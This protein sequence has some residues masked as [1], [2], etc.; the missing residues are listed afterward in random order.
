MSWSTSFWSFCHKLVLFLLASWIMP[1]HS[2]IKTQDSLLRLQFFTLLCKVLITYSL[3]SRNGEV[4]RARPYHQCVS[5]SIPGLHVIHVCGLSLVLVLY[6]T[7]K[8]FFSLYSCLSLSSKT[9]I[10]KFRFDPGMHMHLWTSSCE[11]LGALWL[12]K[13]HCIML[14]YLLWVPP[15]EARFLTLTTVGGE[16]PSIT[17]VP[18]KRLVVTS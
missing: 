16:G 14:H 2:L 18:Y 5:S 17:L 6:F 3:G 9:N 12:I 8:V 13:S 10:S 4:A 1:A 11:L 7:L 15:S